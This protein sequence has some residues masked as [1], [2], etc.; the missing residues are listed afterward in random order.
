MRPRKATLCSVMVGILTHCWR[1]RGWIVHKKCYRIEIKGSNVVC[2]ESP[3]SDCRLFQDYV[4]QILVCSAV[5]KVINEI[6]GIF[7]Q[8]I[9][10]LLLDSIQFK[11]IFIVCLNQY[12][13]TF[14]YFLVVSKAKLQT[15]KSKNKCIFF[16]S[17]FP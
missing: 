3:C 10:T 9:L 2:G 17:P 11:N 14:I 8:H 5:V 6:I 12:I 4:V 13:P 15:T 16:I 1:S 7:Y